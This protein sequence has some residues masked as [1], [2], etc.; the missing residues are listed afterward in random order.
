MELEKIVK[1]L[2]ASLSPKQ[3][4]D[5]KD[6]LLMSLSFAVLVYISQRIVCAYCAWKS[7]NHSSW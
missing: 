4:G 2:R 6:M 5:G 1:G 3:K 7:F